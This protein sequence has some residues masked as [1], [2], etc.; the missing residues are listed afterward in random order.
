MACNCVGTVA[1]LCGHGGGTAGCQLWE[2]SSQTPTLEGSGSGLIRHASWN[3]AADPVACG[4]DSTVLGLKAIGVESRLD[5]LTK[6]LKNK[7]IG[8][9]KEGYI[10]DIDGLRR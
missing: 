4:E 3:D 2:C 5:N 10:P 9:I 1:E 7:F 8:I 6:G